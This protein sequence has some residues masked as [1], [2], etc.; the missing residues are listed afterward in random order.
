MRC[1]G[2]PGATQNCY[3]CLLFFIKKHAKKRHEKCNDFDTASEILPIT[4]VEPASG[5]LQGASRG[6]LK[7]HFHPLSLRKN[8]FR[9]RR[10]LFTNV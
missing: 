1:S 6:A 4:P 3:R 5:R 8:V 7:S 2:S 9:K 10:N